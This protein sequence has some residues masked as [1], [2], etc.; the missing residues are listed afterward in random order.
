MENIL[1]IINKEKRTVLMGV[2]NITP[3]SFSDGG[4]YLNP[5]TAIKRAK[6][7][8]EQGADIIDIG[9]E[10][11][12]PGAD[13]ISED[14][15]LKRAAPIIK[16][17]AKTI[18]IPISIDTYKPKVADIC[19]GLGASIINDIAGIDDAM[20][21]VAVK[22]DA[23]VIIMHMRG[24][25]KTMQEN[26]NS[27]NIIPEIKNFFK[28]RIEKAQIAGI[29]NIIIDPGVGFGKTLEQ[30]LAIIKNLKEF[31]GL[32]CPIL[33]GASRKSFIGK[34]TGL[35]I[36]QRLEGTIA[37]SVAGILNGANIIRV[38]DVLACKRAAMVTDAIKNIKNF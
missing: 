16:S 2:L 5:E 24:K 8:I 17:L 18:D 15:E 30:N 20:R 4:K 9:G 36:S 25:P 21:E 13:P 7:M 35:D 23:G 37:S 22:R 3:D 6:E 14:E 33:I 27:K 29:K 38:H 32:N 10:S 31:K 26:I 1:K 28:K 12:R 11:S 19:L 34:I